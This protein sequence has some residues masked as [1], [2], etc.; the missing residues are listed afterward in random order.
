MPLRVFP[1]AASKPRPTFSDDYGKP[2]SGGRQHAGTDIFAPLGTDVL[3]VDSGTMRHGTSKLG[4]LVAHLMADDGTYYYYGHLDEQ[5][6]ESPRRV[7]AGEPIGRV[8]ATGNAAGLPPHLHFEVHPQNGDPINP[9]PLL[10]QLEPKS[11]I[12]L[13]GSQPRTEPPPKKVLAALPRRAAGGP[14][15][16]LSCSSAP[17]RSGRPPTSGIARG[18]GA[19]L[20]GEA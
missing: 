17:R 8:G 10:A 12:T 15:G 3:A 19:R 13:P 4:G 18:G 9:F 5:L 14:L 11:V 1:V 16:L 6:G 20:R 2:R 7:E